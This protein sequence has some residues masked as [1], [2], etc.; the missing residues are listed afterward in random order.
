MPAAQLKETTM[1]PKKRSLLRVMLQDGSSKTP[2]KSK[3]KGKA[4][5]DEVEDLVERLMGRNPETRFQF[6][7]ENAQFVQDLDI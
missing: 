3:G 7:Q 2:T 4:S 6:I 1:D 5:G